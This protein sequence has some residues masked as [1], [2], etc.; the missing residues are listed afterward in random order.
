MSR[1]GKTIHSLVAKI[2]SAIGKASRPNNHGRGWANLVRKDQE[3]YAVEI[4]QNKGT[5]ELRHY[6][7]L[8]LRLDYVNDKITHF[9]GRSSSD[10]DSMNTFLDHFGHDRKEHFRLKQGGIELVVKQN[11]GSEKYYLSPN[12]LF[13]ALATVGKAD[14]EREVFRA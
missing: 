2:Q 4:D 8:T 1:Y 10:R 5:A 13:H 11:D 14:H 6:G 7:T 12:D 9:Y 3:V